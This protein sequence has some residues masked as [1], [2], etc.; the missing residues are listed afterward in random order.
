MPPSPR[1][2]PLGQDSWKELSNIRSLTCL[3]KPGKE[4]QLPRWAPTTGHSLPRG[5]FLQALC[6]GSCYKPNLVHLRRHPLKIPL[7]KSFSKAKQYVCN[8]SVLPILQKTWAFVVEI[9]KW[10]PPQPCKAHVSTLTGP[11]ASAYCSLL[12]SPCLVVNHT[13]PYVTRVKCFWSQVGVEK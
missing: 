9:T 2:P 5:C 3:G 10:R 11:L 13:V 1:A 6:E 4:K 8:E 12:I 7:T